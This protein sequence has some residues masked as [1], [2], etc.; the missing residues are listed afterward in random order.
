MSVAETSVGLNW[1][2][3][4][5]IFAETLHLSPF[6]CCSGRW[7][8]LTAF[9]ITISFVMLDLNSIPCLKVCLSSQMVFHRIAIS[10]VFPHAV[11]QITHLP[12]KT[13]W[14]KRIWNKVSQLTMFNLRTCIQILMTAFFFNLNYTTDIFSNV[15]LYHLQM[16]LYFSC[17]VLLSYSSLSSIVFSAVRTL[18]M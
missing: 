7:L 15:T 3:N 10:I 16:T 6:E 5:N 13:G 11:L 12:I 18:E 1:Y 14:K 8:A 2:P 4:R 9:T 17:F